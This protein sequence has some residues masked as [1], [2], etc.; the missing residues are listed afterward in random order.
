MDDEFD[1]QSYEGNVFD[2]ADEMISNQAQNIGSI[3]LQINRPYEQRKINVQQ[4][5]IRAMSESVSKIIGD[6]E[7]DQEDFYALSEN[8]ILEKQILE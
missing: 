4:P 1:N 7:S 3:N 2:Q 8:E 6:A 5:K